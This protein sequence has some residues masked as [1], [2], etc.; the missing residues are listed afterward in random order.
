MEPR[1]TAEGLSTLKTQLGYDNY[2]WKGLDNASIHTSLAICLFYAVTI[3]AF[4]M[5]KPEQ[6]RSIA[7]IK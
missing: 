7:Y 4:K 2:T 6:A 3:A 5:G 1:A